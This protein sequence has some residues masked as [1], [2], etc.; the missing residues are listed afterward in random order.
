MTGMQ[1]D[2]DTVTRPRFSPDFDRE[3]PMIIDGH[4]VAGPSDSAFQCV[5]PYED[6]EWGVVYAAGTDQVDDAV[7]AARR[8]FDDDGWAA[9]PATERAAL[10][11]RLA[12]LVDQHADEL[13]LLQIHENGK[14]IGEMSGGITGLALHAR[15]VADLVGSRSDRDVQTGMPNLETVISSAPVGVVAAVTPWNSPLTLLAWKLLP[16]LG[17][18]CTLVIKPSEVTPASTVRLAE[19]CLEAGYPAGVVNV[20]TGFGTPTA[21]HL[22]E[23][24]G[25]D[26]IAFTGSTRTGQAV[27]RAAAA[28]LKRLTLELGGKSPQLVLRDA[29]LDQAVHGVMAGIFAATGQTC[30]AGSRVIVEAPIYDEFVNRLATATDNLLL[31]DPLDPSVDV[32]PLSN[33]RQLATVLSYLD[34]GR[35]SGARV[36]A[37]GTR[38]GGTADLERGFFVRPTVFA[39]V[40][41]RSRIAREEIFG[42]VVAVSRCESAEDAVRIANDSEFGLAAGVWTTDRTQAQ[43]V[44]AALRVGTVWINTYRVLHFAMPFGGFKM[45]GY[46]RELG[47]DALDAYREVK[48]VWT[49]TG[50]LQ[51][52]GRR[53]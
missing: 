5:D 51:N 19:L 40:D 29:D 24:P 14:L 7:A 25:I 42:P 16:A 12:D 36:A 18:G 9:T 13:T 53:A 17:A 44:A 4:A 8:A 20:V 47:P 43:H 2:G 3:Y 11:R 37:G 22:V 50:N 1:Q 38:A 33:R 28:G 39:D 52:F 34:V 15:Y 45:S 48:S 27:M 35:D 41:P 30:L 21:Q 32:G 26:K 10:L 49:D 23:H 31:G 46:G 6:R